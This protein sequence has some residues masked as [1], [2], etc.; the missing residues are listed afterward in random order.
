MHMI[1]CVVWSTSAHAAAA[2]ITFTMSDYFTLFA[3]SA[4]FM[5]S[6][7]CES[8]H[9]IYSSLMPPLS[10]GDNKTIKDLTQVRL[11]EN[12]TVIPGEV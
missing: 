5:A 10:A 2:V 12:I 7:P 11:A 8:Q 3:L 1:C 4:N 9:I 6:S